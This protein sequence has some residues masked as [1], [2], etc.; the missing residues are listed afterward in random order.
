MKVLITGGH[1]GPALAVISAL[2]KDMEVV[3]V[4]RKYTF[5]G[6]MGYS[7]EYQT[8]SKMGIP[9]IPLTTGR[10]QRVITP[11]TLKSLI[12]IPRGI[13]E[14]IKILRRE[15][16][17]VVLG[18]GGYLSLPIGF[19]AKILGIPLVIHEQILKVGMANKIL[20]KFATKICL[21]W[22]ESRQFFPHEK[23][24][25]TGNP[26][27]PFSE[28]FSTKLPKGNLPLLVV[29]G[30]SGGSHA[31]NVVIEQSL[32]DLVYSFRILHQTGDAREFGDFER[33][34]NLK[35]SLPEKE[36]ERYEVVKFIRPEDVWGILNKA[37]IV[38]GRSGINTVTMLLVL[39][40]NSLL[41]PLPHGQ[42]NEQEEN[43]KLLANYG[44]AKIL[45]Q[46]S[47]D[48]KN[49]AIEVKKAMNQKVKDKELLQKKA[50]LHKYAA[51]RIVST[52]KSCA[53]GI[54]KEEI[55]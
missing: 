23:V 35:G 33:L 3:Y 44:L 27:L 53:Q 13:F 18:F 21:S 36:R 9:F 22:E 6:D 20:G 26:L 40:K 31:I 12:K 32:K 15:K 11:Y 55:K 4:G 29:V 24:V 51:E 1:M 2:P 47:I 42:K 17:D 54:S 28:K 5:E 45:N 25:L 37:D 19:A 14:A 38:V 43:A 46:N 34:E 49:F 8:I 39:I 10:F 41:I 52:I 16:P 30:G 50:E 7:L 48:P